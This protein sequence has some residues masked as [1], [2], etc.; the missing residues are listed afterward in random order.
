M[1]GDTGKLRSKTANTDTGKY[2]GIFDN[3]DGTR[4]FKLFGESLTGGQVD[5]LPVD[6]LDFGR[7]LLDIFL[8]SG[9]GY[10]HFILVDFLPGVGGPGGACNHCQCQACKQCFL[11][12]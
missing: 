7:N 6:N 10:H 12:F 1:L 3:T 4:F 2:S 11:H 8:T 5:I 9:G